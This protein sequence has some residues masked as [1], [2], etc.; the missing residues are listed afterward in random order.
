MPSLPRL[1]LSLAYS[2]VCQIISFALLQ[3]YPLAVISAE[4]H[5]RARRR[6][7]THGGEHDTP[8]VYTQSRYA[9]PRLLSGIIGINSYTLSVRNADVLQ[10]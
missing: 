5:L 4:L 9:R 3:L 2:L 10:S 8:C 1:I 6:R 7:D